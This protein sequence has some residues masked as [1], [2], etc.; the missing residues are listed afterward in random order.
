MNTKQKQQSRD[1]FS[2]S[3]R[4][5]KPLL[6]MNPVASSAKLFHKYADNKK[7]MSHNQLMPLSDYFRILR[8]LSVALQDETIHLSPRHLIPGTTGYII[9]NIANCQNL[10]TAMRLI[11]KSYN[12]L[13]GG[14]YNRVEIKNGYLLYIIDDT[15]FPYVM[16]SEDYIHITMEC[17]LIY[18]QGLLSYSTSCDLLPLLRKVYTKRTR[19]PL[20][21]NH[22]SY[23]NVPIRYQAG[24]YALMY[25]LSAAKLPI[26]I[27]PDHV[28]SSADIYEH[29]ITMIS[30]IDDTHKTMVDIKGRISLALEQGIVKQDEV[31]KYLGYS[32]A[33]LKRRLAVENTTFRQHVADVL[34]EKAKVLMSQGMHINDVA[35]ELGFSDFRSF[36]RAFKN[37]NT[38]TPTMY[39]KTIDIK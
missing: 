12:V 26:T 7:R 39:L 33:T 1:I 36:I 27:D 38:I 2:V 18:L 15:M 9:S 22:M 10:E 29:V 3:Q 11:A 14:S 31:A 4:D 16:K 30:Q 37:W 34:N 19:G 24:K 25:D 28:S 23:W 6:D 20:N 35:D 13:H 5:I 17:V 8:E 21:S 32:V